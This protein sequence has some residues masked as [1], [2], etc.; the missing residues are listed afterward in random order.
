M[1]TPQPTA[2]HRPTPEPPL[3]LLAVTLGDPVGIGPEI[4]A[5][6]LADPATTALGRGLA[7]GDAAVL[8]RAVAVCGLDVE[9]N[10]V[11]APGEARFE[12]GT[13]DVL[14]LGIAPADLPWGTVEAGAGRAAPAPLGWPPP[15]PRA[16]AGGGRGPPPRDT[17]S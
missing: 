12:P 5:R 9:V 13:I 11:G 8:R 7:V 15:G 17:R 16:R 10:A 14:D 3:P 2:G 6:T 1:T 4:T